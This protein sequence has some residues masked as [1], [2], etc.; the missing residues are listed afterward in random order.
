VKPR[1][2]V[3]VFVAALLVF[4]LMSVHLVW[5]FQGIAAEKNV[6]FAKE[7]LR[8]LGSLTVRYFPDKKIEGGEAF[9]KSI[10]RP[11]NPMKDPWGGDFLLEKRDEG[12]RSFFYWYSAGP[13]RV[14]G[15]KDDLEFLVPYAAADTYPGS[16]E[17]FYFPNEASP[18]SPAK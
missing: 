15:T 9:W 1:E 17:R 14:Q 12:S 2:Q 3:V 18:S 10:G 4:A 8:K 13:D 11:G 5:A 7:N 6:I 16:E